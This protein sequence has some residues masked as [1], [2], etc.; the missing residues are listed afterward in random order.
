MPTLLTAATYLG[1]RSTMRQFPSMDEHMIT[2]TRTGCT[3]IQDRKIELREEV[4]DDQAFSPHQGSAGP[5]SEVFGCIHRE[6]PMTASRET[7]TE[8]LLRSSTTPQSGIERERIS[9]RVNDRN[10]YLY[11]N[12]Q[13]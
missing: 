9:R 10:R 11:I 2:E 12:T 4:G 5:L 13:L 6:I 1:M 3:V 8:R 7:L